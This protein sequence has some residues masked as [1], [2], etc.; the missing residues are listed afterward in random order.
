MHFT[1]SIKLMLTAIVMVGFASWLI[2]AAP[3]GAATSHLVINC[4]SDDAIVT[5]AAPSTPLG[6]IVP[7]LQWG[8]IYYN[9]GRNFYDVD[10]YAQY[11]PCTPAVG[12]ITAAVLRIYTNTPG[13]VCVNFVDATINEATLTW[14]NQPAAN[15]RQRLGCFDN[16]SVGWHNLDLGKLDTNHLMIGRPVF[17]GTRFTFYLEGGAANGGPGGVSA[18]ARGTDTASSFWLGTTS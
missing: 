8:N 11:R 6:V 17:S 4:V 16:L 10:S 13:Y 18:G 12:T 9:N 2:P 7:W 15:L 1:R 14:N 3:A 5:T